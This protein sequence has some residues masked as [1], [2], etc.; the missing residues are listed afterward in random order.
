MQPGDV[1]ATWADVKDLVDDFG[2]KPAMSVEQGVKNFVTW[3]RGF[4]RV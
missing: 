2:Y 4:Y 3:F 1:P